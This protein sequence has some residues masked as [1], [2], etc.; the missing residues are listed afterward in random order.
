M[1][2]NLSTSSI[3]G[4][5][6]SELRWLWIRTVPVKP[7]GWQTNGKPWGR[8]VTKPSVVLCIFHVYIISPAFLHT[9]NFYNIT[10][11][12]KWI[13]TWGQQSNYGESG[14]RYPKVPED[15]FGNKLV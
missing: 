1:K 11:T 14:Q 15:G 8:N 13:E 5:L 6:E 9:V 10:V 12:F 3:W 7:A 4:A 2:N